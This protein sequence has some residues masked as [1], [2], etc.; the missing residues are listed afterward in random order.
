MFLYF[1]GTYTDR[2]QVSGISSISDKNYVLVNISTKKIEMFTE[3]DEI[4]ADV[5]QTF[6][7]LESIPDVFRNDTKSANFSLEQCKNVNILHTS[8]NAEE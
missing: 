2:R 6:D 1:F 4:S 8:K 3:F 5:S 7:K